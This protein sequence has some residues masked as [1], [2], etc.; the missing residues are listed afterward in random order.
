MPETPYFVSYPEAVRIL[1]SHPLTLP[2]ETVTLDQ[3]FNRI[4]SR[5]LESKV[6]DP[7][8]DNSAM[9]G[10]AFRYED[11]TPPPSHLQIIQTVQAGP[12]TPLA[13]VE[14]GQAARIMTGAPIPDGANAILPIERCEVDEVNNI[15]TLTEV[16]KKH[17]IRKQ[18]ENLRKGH[19][20]LHKGTILTPSSI[21]LC[22][23]MGYPEIP[24]FS[25]AK[26]GV[27]STGD[28]LQIPGT[29]LNDWEIYESNSFG[30]ISLVKWSGHDAK[31]YSSVVDS[32][33]NL[34]MALNQAAE[35]CDIILTSGGVSMGEWDLVRK[36][37][38]EEGD[39]KFWRVKIRPGSPPLFGYWKGVPL[40]GLPGNPASSHV[41]FR[42]LVG[43]Y[44][45][46]ATGG[47]GIQER[48]GRVK[49]A[50]SFKTDGN[51]LTLRRI[52]VDTTGDNLLAYSTGYQG[53]GNLNSLVLADALTLLEP[54]H[55]GEKGTWCDALLL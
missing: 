23:T 44:L 39:I 15:V 30:L 10:F 31:R 49:L 20:A 37:M 9:D 43:P 1:E 13:V 35:E 38:E 55:S 40:F 7:R 41:V 46:A 3:G 50:E 47:G 19:T 8:Y 33:D 27:I 36:L 22:A 34:R 11:S 18:G 14:Q 6:D 52:K 48:R 21:G 29:P 42:M 2:T 51:N 25:Q 24:V 28:E 32:L 26:I 16:G 5:D 17:F 4:L 54:G 45:R 53:S 12:K